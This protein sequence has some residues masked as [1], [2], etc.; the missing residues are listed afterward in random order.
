[1]NSSGLAGLP[2]QS[3]DGASTPGGHAITLDTEISVRYLFHLAFRFPA[4]SQLNPPL[5]L[6]VVGWR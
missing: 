1:M 2:G 6:F 4:L 5:L 3:S